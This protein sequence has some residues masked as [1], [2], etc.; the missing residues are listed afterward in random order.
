MLCVLK[1]KFLE[2]SKLAD[3]REVAYERAI[4]FRD[5]YGLGNYC[6]SKLL[7]ILEL[8]GKDERIKIELIRTPFN[9]LKL[10][11]F[12]GFKDG[13]F[14]I[15]TNTNQ[16]LGY[17]TFT[18]AHEIYHLLQNRVYIKENAI[19]EE[20]VNSE[21][22]DKDINELMAD[23]FAA[24]LLIPKES[25]KE[26]VMELVDGKTEDIDPGTI[27]QL[28]HK[29]GVDYV[30]VTKRLKE[31]GIIDDLQK[32][33]LEVILEV[34]GKLQDITKKLG[35]SNELNTPSKDTYILQKNLEVIK[36]NFE[37]EYTTYDDLVRIFGYLGCPPEKFGYEESIVLSEGAKDF[38]KSLED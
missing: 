7:D 17:E 28:Q 23:S 27:I 9:N 11:G 10:A 37:N 29:Y 21:F 4:N 1:N 32:G 35:R 8:L 12:I 22:S 33:S 18:I 3:L 36:S 19:I 14:V 6:A 24:E 34:E 26:N 2:V 38:M 20:T 16:T 13:T 31:I 25:L 15:V 5:K 30:A